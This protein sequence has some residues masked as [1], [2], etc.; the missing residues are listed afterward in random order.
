[1]SDLQVGYKYDV[2]LS[3]SRRGQWS[4]FVDKYFEP[5]LHHWLGEE[6]GRNPV[7]FRDARTVPTG[8]D[9]HQMLEDA[10]RASRVMIALWSRQYFSSPWCQLELSFMLGRADQFKV[11]GAADRII[12]PATIHDGRSFPNFLSR[13]QTINLS[14]YS[15]PFMNPDSILRERL[16]E[17]LQRF[18]EDVASAIES[19]PDGSESWEV[20]YKQ[21]LAMFSD[22]GSQQDRPPSLGESA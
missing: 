15:D 7:V 1:M 4:S 12:L 21:Y 11:R 13:L 17:K 18:C 16:S 3:Y 22:N 9:W 8:Q 20:D 19:V 10:L 14:E 2:F 6:L 5:I